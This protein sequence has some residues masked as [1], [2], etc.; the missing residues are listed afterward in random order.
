LPILKK[1]G[2]GLAGIVGVLLIFLYVVSLAVLRR[3]PK[4][5]RVALEGV[6]TLEQA[7]NLC[8]RS[9]LEGWELV[10]F[11]QNLAAR[12][13]SYSRLNSWEAPARAFERGRGYCQQQAQ[14]LKKILDGLG[15]EAKLVYAL[16]CQFPAKEVD[17]F[18]CPAGI[19]SHTWLRVRLANREEEKEKEVCCGATTNR[20]G[21][22]HFQ[23][24]SKVHPLPGW[25]LPFSQFGSAIE[26]IRRDF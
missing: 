1:L 18:Y 20:P 9:G 2:L 25:L 7:I 26:N 17:G 3:L 8:R 12:K 6:T 4:P 10:A 14:A 11:A 21:Q 23:I 5:G 13:F 15:I 22:V 19:S 16:R 24:L